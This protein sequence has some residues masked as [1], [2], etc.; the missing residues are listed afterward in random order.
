MKCRAMGALSASVAGCIDQPGEVTTYSWYTDGLGFSMRHA[1][2]I[3][4]LTVRPL[5]LSKL[6]H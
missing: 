1:A 3:E 5:M 2:S 4:R 6:Q